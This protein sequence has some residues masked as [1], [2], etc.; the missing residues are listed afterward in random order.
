LGK[1]SA[2]L[3]VIRTDHV[4]GNQLPFFGRTQWKLKVHAPADEND[5]IASTNVS[6][7]DMAIFYLAKNG[8]GSV[9]EIEDWD[10]DKFLDALEYEAIDN[11]IARHLRWKAEQKN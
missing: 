1:V 2:R 6:T 8:Y 10:T 7:D 3:F 9:N 5:F 4:G 11:A